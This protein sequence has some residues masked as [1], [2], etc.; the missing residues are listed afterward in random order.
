[1]NKKFTKIAAFASAL[2][3]TLS[4]TGV[5]YAAENGNST[6]TTANAS[7][8]ETTAVSG[9]V[10]GGAEASK[11]KEFGDLNKDDVVNAK[12]A[13]KVLQYYAEHLAKKAEGKDITV[14]EFLSGDSNETTESTEATTTVADA[15][16]DAKTTTATTTADAKTTAVATTAG[17]KATTAATTTVTED[18]TEATT[19]GLPVVPKNGAVKD[20]SDE[21][22]GTEAATTTEAT[23]ATSA[24]TTSVSTTASTDA[25]T[26]ATTETS[27]EKKYSLG[28][29]N[30]DGEVDSKDAVSILSYYAAVLAGSEQ[31]E[32]TAATESTE[33][34]TTAVT[35]VAKVTTTA[36]STTVA[37]TTTVKATEVATTEAK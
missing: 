29:V 24:V 2:V 30:G 7:N 37:A 9:N 20:A 36:K 13:V 35:T 18:T 21:T 28:D 10:Y 34:A 22:E 19:A 3:L 6:E 11:I 31:N 33:V 1:M 4:A 27:A 32:T 5:A 17:T 12:D 14:E 15:T 23:T 16:A 8:T 25:S 26:E